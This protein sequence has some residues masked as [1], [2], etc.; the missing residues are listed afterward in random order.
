MPDRSKIKYFTSRFWWCASRFVSPAT[1]RL[2]LSPAVGHINWLFI[3]SS[4]KWLFVFF[5]NAVGDVTSGQKNRA[6][7]QLAM[8]FP[9][10]KSPGCSKGFECVISH[11]LTWSSVR[12]VCRSDAS[13]VITKTKF[14]ALM[15]LPISLAMGL[16]ARSSAINQAGGQYCS[17]L[18]QWLTKFLPYV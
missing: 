4:S 7:A 15:G 18:F 12:T 14:L 2:A 1:R 5:S 9:A 17:R 8:Q 3:L 10:E 6:A 13:D 16:R 11:W